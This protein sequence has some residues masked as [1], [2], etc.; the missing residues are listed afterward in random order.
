MQTKYYQNGIELATETKYNSEAQKWETKPIPLHSE[1]FYPVIEYTDSQT[2]AE[3][4]I[5]HCSA[6]RD[7]LAEMARGM[8]I[9]EIGGYW[10][11]ADGSE[12]AI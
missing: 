3:W 1:R 7:L 10:F 6:S 5:E 11:F 4:L 12:I 2:I 9:A 8:A